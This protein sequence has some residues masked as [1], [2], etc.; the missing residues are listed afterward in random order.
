VRRSDPPD[1]LSAQTRPVMLFATGPG[2]LHLRCI[3]GLY[4]RL[5]EGGEIERQRDRTTL[6]MN[7]IAISWCS[8]GVRCVERRWLQIRV[9]PKTPG[10][11][12]WRTAKQVPFFSGLT[13]HGGILLG[14]VAAVVLVHH[15]SQQVGLRNPA[16]R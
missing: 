13:L 4:P 14:L 1:S 8:L 7:Y 6:M 12:G 3:V 2:R 5:L 11:R 16:D 9:F 10:C 15:L